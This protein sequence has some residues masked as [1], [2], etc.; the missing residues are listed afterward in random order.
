MEGRLQLMSAPPL[1]P[2][3][4][5]AV[6][7]DTSGATDVARQVIDGLLPIAADR[8]RLRT[9][10]DLL[11]APLAWCAP[12]WHIARAALADRPAPALRSLREQLDFNVDRSI[13]AAVKLLTERGCAVR[14]VTGSMLATTV[15][16]TL[17]A[18]VEAGALVGLVGA[19]ALGPTAILNIIGTSELARTVPTIIVTTSMKLVPQEA[20]QSL[21]G[22]GFERVPLAQF[23]AV[24]L[25]GEVVTPA[26]AGQRASALSAGT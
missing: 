25:D 14:T 12:M 11:A 2:Q 6:Q 15:A 18:P 5:A 7:D 26:E 24:V 23:E 16:E 20:F 19:D 4:A 21:T 17:P 10:V 13:A 1:P 9:T 3:L 22:A 8:D